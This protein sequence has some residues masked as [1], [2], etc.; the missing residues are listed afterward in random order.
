M[1]LA[2]FEAVHRRTREEHP[3]LVA[4]GEDSESLRQTSGTFFWKKE[5]SGGNLFSRFR[6]SAKQVMMEYSRK[7]TRP[8]FRQLHQVFLSMGMMD[9][10]VSRILVYSVNPGFFKDSSLALGSLSTFGYSFISS[11]DSGGCWGLCLSSHRKSITYTIG[12]GVTQ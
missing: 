8:I 9:L 7:K 12:R 5:G 4:E 11:I 3:D 6:T 10:H 2:D 1:P